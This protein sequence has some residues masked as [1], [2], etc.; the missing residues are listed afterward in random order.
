MMECSYASAVRS[1][2]DDALYV[3]TFTPSMNH[4]SLLAVQLTP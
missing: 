2:F 3:R 4:S 1:L